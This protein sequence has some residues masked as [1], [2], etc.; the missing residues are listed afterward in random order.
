MKK[1]LLSLLASLTMGLG[2]QAQEN[3][4]DDAFVVKDVEIKAGGKA[5][6]TFE[7]TKLPANGSRGFE[8]HVYLPERFSLETKSNGRIKTTIESP[9][10]EEGDWSISGNPQEDP[11]DI[12]FMGTSTDGDLLV[13]GPVFSVTLQADASVKKGIYNAD[14]AGNTKTSDFIIQGKNGGEAFLSS[15]FKIRIFVPRL[16][17]SEEEN[18]EEGFDGTLTDVNVTMNTR[19]IK[20]G[21]WNTICLPFSMDDT[22]IANAFGTDNEVS[23][24]EFTGYKKTVNGENTNITLQFTSRS[25]SDGLSAN[26]PYLIKLKDDVTTFTVNGTSFETL[27]GD[28]PQVDKGVIF[29]GN[30]VNLE[31]LNNVMYISNNTVKVAKGK[32]KLKSFRGY[33]IY[34]GVLEEASNG[35]NISVFVDG[36]PT[37]IR[38]I[39]TDQDNDDVYDISGRKV[40][41]DKTTLQKGIYI[42]NGKKETVH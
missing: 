27:V 31:N 23:L 35:A 20:G 9:N 4:L 41:S 29:R 18:Y 36:E 32:T 34:E 2:V 15:P 11:Q 24:A 39:T 7:L 10:S 28:Y 17:L 12:K 13:L 8:F 5:K 40:N 22:Q 3:R 38:S 30:Y 37:G 14:V 19:T 21:N 33:F 6:M 25:L 26:T 16:E 1:L 42:I